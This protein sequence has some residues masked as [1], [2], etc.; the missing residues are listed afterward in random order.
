MKVKAWVSMHLVGC[1]RR[2]EIEI[3]DGTSEDEIEEAV[4]E[5]MFEQIEWGYDLP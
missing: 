3:E 2:E 1:E 4:R 5:W